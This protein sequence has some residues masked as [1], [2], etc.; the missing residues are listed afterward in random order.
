MRW[1]IVAGTLLVICSASSS[2]EL[3]S[4]GAGESASGQW[5]ARAGFVTAEYQW[6]VTVSIDGPGTLTLC[7][8]ARDRTALMTI[9]GPTE[10]PRTVALQLRA[11]PGIDGPPW[12]LPVRWTFEAG[13]EPATCRLEPAAGLPMPADFAV[14][15]EPLYQHHIPRV[16]EPPVIDGDLSDACWDDAAYIGDALWG[17]FNRPAEAAMATHVWAVYDDENLY[18]AFRCET[19]DVRKLVTKV[20]E[21]DGPAWRDDCAEIFID[22]GHD[23]HTYYEF[24]VTPAEVV[25][26][27][28]WIYDGGQWLKDWDYIGEWKTAIEEDAW[29]V[30]IRL[31]LE[32]F[33]RRDLRGNPVGEMPLPTGDVAGILFSRMD[34]VTGEGASHAHNRPSFHEVHQYGHLVGFR[35]NRPEA[36]RRTAL[37]RFTDLQRSWHDLFYAAGAPETLPQAA[38]EFPVRIEAL[39]DAIAAPEVDFDGWVSIGREL[40]ALETLLEAARAELAPMVAAARWPEAPWGM[41]VAAPEEPAAAQ[42]PHRLDLSGARGE[43]VATRLRLLPLQEEAATGLRV[44]EEPL[45]G[46]GAP[47]RNLR[48]YRIDDGERLIPRGAARAGDELWWEID[49]P[50]DAAPGIYEGEI[51]TSDGEQRVALPVRLTVHDFSLPPTPSLAVSVG[52]DARRMMELWYGEPSAIGAGEYRPYAEA[53]LRHRLVPREMLADLTRWS[54]EAVDFTDAEGML[55]RALEF[56]VNPRALIAARPQDLAALAEPHAALEAAVAHWRETAEISPLATYLPDGA[57]VLDPGGME[58]APSVAAATVDTDREAISGYDLWAM[59]P[60]SAVCLG[61]C[62]HA[63]LRAVA[64]SLDRRVEWRIAEAPQ[65]MIDLRMLGWLADTYRRGVIFWDAPDGE[66]TCASGLLVCMEDGQRL[67]EPVETVAL[68]MLR[69]AV[70]DYEYLTLLR[71]LDRRI[72]AERL[73]TRF[74]RLQQETRGQY[75]RSRDMVMNVNDFNRNMGQ[76]EE[77][78]E[79]AARQIVRTRDWL[80][81]VGVEELPGDSE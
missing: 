65:C 73:G 19:P 46:P 27:C 78:R 68:K 77:R 54:D 75:R 63:R 15:P 36:Y 61:D 21:R 3:V 8:P 70:E 50:L 14:Q 29:V 49:L 51:V 48:W 59:S 71:Q 74:W 34:Q 47:L 60:A 81:R 28:K 76:I 20:T 25:F 1:S 58:S 69:R 30:E 10:Q 32:S 9:T 56:G 62:A 18:F 44:S 12:K 42:V 35:P 5:T 11:N 4:I 66:E 72:S 52:L 37:R 17:L 39:S 41:A 2:H 31:A 40:G 80:R 79:R 57:P 67:I 13:D 64:A 38:G 53:L 26:D 24:I 16:S 43:T 33:E 23:H 7:Y 22:L 45:Y 55:D 6:K